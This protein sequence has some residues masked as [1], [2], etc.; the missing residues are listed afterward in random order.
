L[1][2]ANHYP[3]GYKMIMNDNHRFI[4]TDTSFYKHPTARQLKDIAKS[5]S[6][7]AKIFGWVPRVAMTS[8]AT[9]GKPRLMNSKT[10]Q[11]AIKL[12]DADETINFE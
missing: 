3:I 1:F 8:Y 6:R 4:I 7:L 2:E 12:M 11:D 5:S 9:F 10:V